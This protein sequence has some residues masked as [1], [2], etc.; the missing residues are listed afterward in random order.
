MSAI[1]TTDTFVNRDTVEKAYITAKDMQKQANKGTRDEQ[2][3]AER[4]AQRGMRAVK[5]KD[6]LTLRVLEQAT[7]ILLKISNEQ[8]GQ[9]RQRSDIPESHRVEPTTVQMWRE[10]YKMAD[11]GTPL[12]NF[13]WVYGCACQL[14]YG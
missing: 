11:Q 1:K 9:Y 7:E 14:A 10:A 8:F 4:F 13:R 2:I 12:E 5:S 6:L 3:E